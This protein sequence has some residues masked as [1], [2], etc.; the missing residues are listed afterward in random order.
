MAREYAYTP[1]LEMHSEE[2]HRSSPALETAVVSDHRLADLP[3]T[4]VQVKVGQLHLFATPKPAT[5]LV[6]MPLSATTATITVLLH[7]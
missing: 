4:T 2:G 7:A 6:V 5:V 1:S 3:E